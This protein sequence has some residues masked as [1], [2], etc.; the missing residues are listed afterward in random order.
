MSHG[1]WLSPGLSNSFLLTTD[2]GRI[3]LNTGMGFEGPA[4]RANYDAI[5]TAPI[6]YVI[7]TQGHVDHVGGLDT[8]A[9]SDSEIVAQANWETWR[10]DN[11]LLAEFRARNSAFAWVDKVM[12]TIERNAARFGPPPPQSV[13]TPTIVVDDEL[14]IE[15][16]GR[17]LEL[18]ATPGGETTDSLVVWLPQEEGLPVRKRLRCIVRAHPEPGDDARG[19]LSGCADGGRVH[20]AGPRV[21]RRDVAYRAFRADRR[22]RPDRVGVDATA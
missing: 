3:V 6:R 1:I 2:A 15:L 4:H 8:V 9:D 12:D 20:R 7:L 19:P 17:R 13:P 21:G 16:G 10:R 5:D 22:Q 11:E 18:Y 14:V